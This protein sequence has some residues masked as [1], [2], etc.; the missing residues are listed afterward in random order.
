MLVQLRDREALASLPTICLTTY[1]NSHGWTN[2]GQWG[3]R[4]AIIYTKEDGDSGS[5]VLVPTRD[6]IA[7]YAESMAQ[8]VAVLA[9]VEKRSQFDVY[10]DLMS[11]G[12]DMIQVRSINGSGSKQLSLRQSAH[13]LGD[14]YDLLASAAR[15][16]ERPRSSYRGPLSSEV[17]EYLDNVIP[18]AGD[19]QS[20]TLTL[21]CPVPAGF[22]TQ[23]GMGDEFHAPFSRRATLKLA[24][25]LQ[26]SKNAIAE[27]V[28]D[29]ALASFR[30]TVAYGVSA[31]LCDA[32]AEL[33]KKGEGIEIGLS[34]ADVRPPSPSKIASPKFQFSE[35]SG[36]ILTEAAKTIRRDEPSLDESV[37]AQVVKLEREPEDFDGSATLLCI[38]QG[39]PV[40]MQVQF[41][42]LFYNTVIQAFQTRDLI[43][44]DGDIYRVGNGYSLRN[45]RNLRVLPGE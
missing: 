21:H 20:Y 27:A 37:I 9:A 23:L 36:E 2:Q 38:R 24:E 15:A 7:D 43:S 16:T 18:L 33:A 26:H 19:Y 10:R 39:N 31:N 34:W 44:V 14:A 4:P 11:A 12:A 1:L 32:I 30:E 28:T 42:E 13:L 29:G 3:Q 41:E 45:P 6:S 5:E 40:R 8:S 17:V 35:H 25:A 22:G